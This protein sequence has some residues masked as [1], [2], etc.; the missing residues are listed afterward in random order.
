MSAL[1]IILTGVSLGGLLAIFIYRFV[2]Y[3]NRREF[4]IQLF[5][6]GLCFSILYSFFYAPEVPAM[7]GNGNNEVYFVIVLYFCMLLGMFA[8]YGHIRFSRPKEKWKKTDF[9]LFFAPVFASPIVF[10]PLLAALQNAE[11]DLQNL[12]TAKMMVFF[13]AFE[14]G[15]FWKD[16]FDHRQRVRKNASKQKK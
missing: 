1:M 10:I 8:Q 16:Y 11:I 6:I 5:V 14:N 15:F 2:K 13:V 3:G 4:I 12:T 9:G 7:K